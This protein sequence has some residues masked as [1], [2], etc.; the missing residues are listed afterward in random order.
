MAIMVMGG[1]GLVGINVARQLLEQGQD[2]VVFDRKPPAAKKNVL[3]DLMDKVKV[4]IGNITDLSQVLH[5]VKKHNVKGIINTAVIQG[6]MANRYP[7]EALHVNIIG[8]ANCL[9]AARLLDVQRVVIVSSSAVMGSPEEVVTPKKEEEITLPLSGIYPLSKLTCEHL[10]LTY[11]D[12]YKVDAVAVRPRAIYGPCDTFGGH[13]L[14]MWDIMKDAFEGRSII[15]ESGSDS[16][17]DLTYVK[18]EAKGIIL[19]YQ[20]KSPSYHVY[21]VSYGKN[22]T[23]GEVFAV[24]K[25]VYPKL[26][27][28]VGPGMWGGTLAEGKQTDLT[29]RSSQRPPQDIGR[30]RKDLGYE[31]EWPVERAIPDWAEWLKKN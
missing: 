9:E 14:P 30:A 15:K 4:E 31:P 13:A 22:T 23:L 21:N 7:I 20:C 3:A 29:Y 17:F 2:V 28:Q 11:R 18:D 25:K 16:S 6:T 24:L 8:S 1:T 12:L 19:A 10:T 26:P 5:A 27:I